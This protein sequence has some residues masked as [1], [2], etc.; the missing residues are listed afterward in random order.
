MESNRKYWGKRRPYYYKTI[1]EKENKLTFFS[2]FFF[3]F[4]FFFAFKNSEQSFNL[5]EPSELTKFIFPF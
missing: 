2:L 5:T 4:F 1:N 3:F